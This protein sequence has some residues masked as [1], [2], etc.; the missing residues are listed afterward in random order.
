M[1]KRTLVQTPAGSLAVVDQGDRASA[2]RAPALFVHGVL[3]SADL[4]RHVIAPASAGRRCIAV[5]LP[6]HGSSPL[7]PDQ[8]V[9]ISAFADLLD[10]LCEA[11]EL[12]AVDLVGNDTGG[13][14][15]Q[16]F[17]AR[18]PERVRTL[19]LTNC[20]TIGNLPPAPFAP[21]VELARRGEF[22]ERFVRVASDRERARARGLGPGYERPDEIE[23]ATIDAFL[24]PFRTIEGARALERVIAALDD[25]A[26]VAS[27]RQLAALAAP[28]LIVWGTAD[29]FFSVDEAY[30]LRDLIGAPCEVVELDGAKLFFPDERADELVPILQRHWQAAVPA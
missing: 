23:D 4:W 18:H 20:D 29:E 24:S 8:D 22:A 3:T 11:L 19:T 28:T 2:D 15:C 30:R 13:A 16:V 1:L 5:D 12:E 26:L 9:S 27:Q 21:V 6:G 14:V 10:S 25:S 17:A 7:A